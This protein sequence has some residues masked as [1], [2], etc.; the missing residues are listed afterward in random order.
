MFAVSRSG[1]PTFEA[2]LDQ[3]AKNL[4][5]RWIVNHLYT[6]SGRVVKTMEALK[7]GQGYVAAGGKFVRGNYGNKQ[8]PNWNATGRVHDWPTTG[9]YVRSLGHRLLAI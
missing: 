8:A 7:N 6:T 2:L 5:L 9:T 4:D 1:Y 3:V